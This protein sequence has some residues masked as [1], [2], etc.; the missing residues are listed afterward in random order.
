MFHNLYNLVIFL[1]VYDTPESELKLNDVFEFIGV[2]TF[3]TDVKEEN[4]L[5][6]DQEELINLPSSKVNAR[7]R[8]IS[9]FVYRLDMLTRICFQVPRLHCI[10]H[11]K[12][13]PIDMVVS[14][15]TLEVCY[16]IYNASFLYIPLK[17]FI[18]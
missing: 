6:F 15:P 1:Q 17:T 2:L 12:L 10:I 11:R 13:S 4:E 16:D 18:I 8:F 5:G 9:L 14:S 3:D 7:F